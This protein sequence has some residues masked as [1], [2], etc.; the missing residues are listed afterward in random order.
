[1]KK[2]LTVLLVVLLATSTV[3]AAMNVSGR[4][5]AGYTF[6]FNNGF[7]AEAWHGNNHEAKLTL[8]V[9]DD[10]G[11]WTINVKDLAAGLDGDDKLKANLS[12]N[13]TNL[14]AANGVDLGDFNITGSIG[15]NSA[16]TA[17]SAYNDVTGDEIYKVKNNGNYSSELAV[18]YGDL[19]QAKIAIDP[20]AKVSKEMPIVLSVMSSPISGLS[21]SAAY[22]Y[23]GLIY[24]VD[25]DTK[26]P[27]DHVL[28]FAVN[29]DFA[30]LFGL[31]FQLGL[32]AYDNVGFGYYKE[33]VVGKDDAGKDK[34]DF[35]A[36]DKNVNTFAAAVYGGVDLVDAYFEL[37]MNNQ[38]WKD[39]KS[40]FGMKSQVNLNLVENL[41]LDVY[42]N[43][44]NF[45][46]TADSYAVGGDVSYT[47]SGVEF[48]GNIDY[49]AG[50]EGGFSITPKVII[51]F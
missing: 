2:V 30:A 29:A 10:A 42:F 15:A 8:K 49:T 18:G 3:F 27:A 44:D 5:R 26:V 35:V 1:M 9:S 50:A 51:A 16:M 38:L 28:G 25:K 23:N 13:F 11:I 17:L 19:V 22:A 45:A 6:K 47:I 36:Q 12:L 20:T 40:T 34:Y 41:K 46:K 43:I 48:A 32:A 31:D 21:V 39:G 14:L 33:E 24:Q 7:D 37:R 4:F